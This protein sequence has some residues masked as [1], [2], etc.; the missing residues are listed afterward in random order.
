MVDPALDSLDSEL[1]GAVFDVI[2]AVFPADL[3]RV[4]CRHP[5]LSRI[6]QQNL[7]RVPLVPGISVFYRCA[8]RISSWACGW[9]HRQQRQAHH[10][11]QRKEETRSRRGII[12]PSC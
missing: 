8:T 3:S 6:H 12:G 2:T 10:N 9:S 7:T 1:F 4:Y 11:T 5:L